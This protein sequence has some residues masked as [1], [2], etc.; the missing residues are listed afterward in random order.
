MALFPAEQ[1]EEG[2]FVRQGDAFRSMHIIPIG[3]L[4]DL[5][6]PHGRGALP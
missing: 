1:S 3:P 2:H 4:L 5:E 6:A